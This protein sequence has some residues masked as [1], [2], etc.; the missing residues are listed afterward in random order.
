[1]RLGNSNARWASQPH[2]LSCLTKS[3]VDRPHSIFF[4][5]CVSPS[6]DNIKSVKVESHQSGYSCCLRMHGSTPLTQCTPQTKYP[7][8]GHIVVLLSAEL[9]AQIVPAIQVGPTRPISSLDGLALPKLNS[10]DGNCGEKI[11]KSMPSFRSNFE[12]MRG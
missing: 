12:K 8:L 7:V 6:I 4:F 1:M 10:Q 3:H 5:A 11:R 2:D 9:I